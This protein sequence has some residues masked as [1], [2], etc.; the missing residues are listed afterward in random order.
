MTSLRSK[1]L[2]EAAKVLL[3]SNLREGHDPHY[4]IRYRY[5]CPSLQK[6]RWQWYWDSCFHAIA[7]AHIEPELAVSELESLLAAQEPDGF[8]GH[9]T[10]WSGADR[11]PFITRL[12][13]RLA[14]RPH[15]SALIQPPLIAQAAELVS[16][17][18]GDTGFL[19]R[20]Y[21]KLA[22][23]YRW[24]SENRC[25][26]GDGLIVLISPFESGMD[27]TPAYDRPL[28]IGTMH[29]GWWTIRLRVAGLHVSHL[30]RGGNYHLDRVYKLCR[31]NVKD[32]AVNCIYAEA[33]RAM[34]RIASGLNR[35][36]DADMW[37]AKAERAERAI[38]DILFDEDA[39]TFF[40][41]YGRGRRFSR[42][43]TASC[44][45]PLLLESLPEGIA[46]VLVEQLLLQPE[47]FW[48]EYPLPTVAASEPT[49]LADPGDRRHP[50]IWRG[51]SWININWF[52]ARGL[53]RH[54][55]LDIASS[56]AEKSATLVERSGFREFF[57]P[58]TGEGQGAT[59]FA[60]STLIV[61]M[62]GHGNQRRA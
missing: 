26:D 25:P 42:V 1:D 47:K 49:F 23:H 32:V 30:L 35:P 40:P 38:V 10:Y 48:T 27:N 62:I 11:T 52:V 55:Y 56:I 37:A 36:D 24:L 2:A 34:H 53:R 58:H 3:I 13:S 17:I 43:L 4:G 45:F 14:L 22:A 12:E 60:W 7:L 44:L 39:H 41:T 18:T 6:Y 5:V 54:G 50:L 15:H 46:T 16:E 28:G 19:A 9:V 20:A 29:P 57:N 21:P 59:N 51:S 8:M 61:D 33:L 31:F